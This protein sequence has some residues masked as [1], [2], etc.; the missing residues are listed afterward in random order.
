MKMHTA[1]FYGCMFVTSKEK[2]LQEEKQ[3]FNGLRRPPEAPILVLVA[4]ES[5][6]LVHSRCPTL[7]LFV[8]LTGFPHTQ[9]WS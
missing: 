6:S 1:I 8:K 9:Q 4:A 2:T 3:Y 7:L 5:R